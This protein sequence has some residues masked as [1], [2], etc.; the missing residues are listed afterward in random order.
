MTVRVEQLA[1]HLRR[2]GLAAPAAFLLEAH[3]PLLP[4]LR[5]AG[6]AISPILD[7]LAGEPGM[8][9]SLLDDPTALDR[10]LAELDGDRPPVTG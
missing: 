2:L 10:L 4:L 1:R 3:R 5:Q 8:T 6:I 9:A 7:P